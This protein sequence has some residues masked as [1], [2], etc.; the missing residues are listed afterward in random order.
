MYVRTTDLMKKGLRRVSTAAMHSG[1]AVRTTD[2]MKK[3][4]RQRDGAEW[5]AAGVRTTDL[6]KKGLRPPRS[7]RPGRE[8]AFERLT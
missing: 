6:M 3:G 7:D 8:Q 5:R 2:L 1:R 4:L